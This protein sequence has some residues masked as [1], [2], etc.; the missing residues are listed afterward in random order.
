M[1]QSREP[2]TWTARSAVPGFL[3]STRAFRFTNTFAPQSLLDVRLPRMRWGLGIG[4]ASRGLCGGM[5]FAVRDLHEA[6]LDPPPDTA[7][8]ERGSPLYAY[9]VRR[10]FASFDLPRGVARY[11]AL[12]Y[13][14][15]AVDGHAN[16]KIGQNAPNRRDAGR[17]GQGQPY[18]R[19]ADVGRRSIAG[20]WPRI[21]LDL[22]TGRLSP[23][24]IITVHSADPRRL[25]LNHQV[26]AYA[27]EQVGAAVTLRVHDPNTALDRADDVTMSFDLAR[28]DAGIDHSI[29][30]GGRP[31]R[32]FFR[33]RYRWT[34]P[35]P[36]LRRVGDDHPRTGL[37]PTQAIPYACSASDDRRSG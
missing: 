23:L 14:P 10:L 28:P 37:S 9:L 16:Q 32:A 11:Y 26:L 27:Y 29:S 33:S 3:P 18:A 20:E 15:D 17:P 6:G 12:T 1:S 35:R 22:D 30:I 8:P 5:I 7:P 34:D 2:E 25:G 31:V 19:R 24:G 21:R 13:G 4:D 36:A